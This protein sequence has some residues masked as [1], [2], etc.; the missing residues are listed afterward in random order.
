MNYFAK[1]FNFDISRNKLVT[2]TDKELESFVSTNV[3]ETTTVERRAAE[4][5]L[6]SRGYSHEKLNQLIL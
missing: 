5:I 4:S 6:R 3:Y 2:K 1:Q